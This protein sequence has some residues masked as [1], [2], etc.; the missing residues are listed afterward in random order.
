VTEVPVQG[1]IWW[2]EAQ[3]QRR[4][5][6]VV[7]RSD[8]LPVLTT[9][10]VAP[11]TRT[12]RSIPTEVPLGP[13]HGLPVDCCATFDNLQPIRRALLTERVGRLDVDELDQICQALRSMADC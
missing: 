5:V 8:A 1:E 13:R 11:V 3:D 9:V 10:L 12:V 2:A 4:P 7:T 6:L